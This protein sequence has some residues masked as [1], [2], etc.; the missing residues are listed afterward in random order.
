VVVDTLHRLRQQTLDGRGV[1][2]GVHHAGKD[3]RT[4]RGSTTFEAGADTVYAVTLDETVIILDRQKRKDGPVVDRHELRLG[5][6]E[7]TDSC[8]VESS[9]LGSETTSRAGT[10][11]SHFVSHFAETGATRADLRDS[12]DMPRATF[13]RALN[14]LLKSGRFINEGTGKRPFYRLAEK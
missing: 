13:Y 10:L 6:I 8:V 1:I 9:H 5:R 12:A 2:L 4:F 7:G 14:D 3:G 11:L